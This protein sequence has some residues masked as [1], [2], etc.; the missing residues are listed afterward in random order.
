MTGLS[1]ITAPAIEPL[2]LQEAKA[3]LRVTASDDDSLILALITAVRQS[4]EGRFGELQRALITQ[5]WDWFLDCF[6][7]SSARPLDVPMPP[8]QSVT[9]ITYTDTDGAS[10]TWSAAKYTVDA[11]SLIG[12]VMPAYNETYPETRDVMNAVTV[13]FVAGFGATAADVPAPIRHAM[14]LQIAHLYDNRDTH[15][16]GGS[17]EQLP[18]VRNLLAP[19]WIATF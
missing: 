11:R 5:T 15:M 14:L 6:P 16:I 2:T 7:A 18:A 13:R 1:L 3:H 10:Q 8:L 9:S 4:L 12:R 19:Y 17:V